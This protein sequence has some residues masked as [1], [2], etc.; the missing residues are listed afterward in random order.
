[1]GYC[2]QANRPVVSE[3]EP[4]GQQ[5]QLTAD[6]NILLLICT[7]SKLLGATSLSEVAPQPILYNSIIPSLLDTVSHLTT[8][9]QQRQAAF[10][11][12]VVYQDHG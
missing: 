4:V 11:H 1:M 10:L 5:W 9:I 7:Q 3:C 2:F 12:A 6:A 8:I